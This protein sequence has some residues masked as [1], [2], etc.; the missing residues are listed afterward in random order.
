MKEELR[1][2]WDFYLDSGNAVHFVIE[3]LRVP[4]TM[5]KEEV[6]I[7]I[8]T[9]ILKAIAREGVSFRSVA[10]FAVSHAEHEL[11]REYC[12]EKAQN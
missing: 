10:R 3:Q 4:R 9:D 2:C 5:S 11:E 1:A 6:A 12:C 7:D 8:V